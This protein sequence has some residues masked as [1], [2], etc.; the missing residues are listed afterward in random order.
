MP[1]ALADAGEAL[2]GHTPD[3]PVVLMAASAAVIWASRPYVTRPVGR[4]LVTLVSLSALATAAALVEGLPF[5]VLGTIVLAWG[6]AALAHLALGTAEATPSTE[7][8]TASLRGISAWTSTDLRLAPEQ[9]WGSTTF[10]AGADGDLAHP[11][12]W[13]GTAATPTWT[14]KVWRFIW[15]KDSEPTLTLTTGYQI[16][17]QA[18]VLLLAGKTGARVPELVAAG[19]AGWRDDAVLVVRNPDG[20]PL[21]PRRSRR[22]TDSV[23][24]DAW[25]GSRA[26]ARCSHRPLPR[27]RAT[28]SSMPV[29]PS[30]SSA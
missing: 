1:E 26:P 20:S 4:T 7:Q 22:L 3:F 30:G 27:G 9:S 18:Y 21:V 17:H 13:A 6:A 2:H 10:L 28:W 29:A 12:W 8:V 15:Y 11:W 19:L 25:A 14:S 5:G 23:L 24:D 16:E